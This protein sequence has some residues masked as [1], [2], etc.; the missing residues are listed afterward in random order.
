MIHSSHQKVKKKGVHN[1]FDEK[2]IVDFVHRYHFRRG[3]RAAGCSRWTESAAGR[4]AVRAGLNLL[5]GGTLF[6]GN[7][8]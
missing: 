7:I 2:A 4:L 3:L 1:E 8:L 6:G 5:L